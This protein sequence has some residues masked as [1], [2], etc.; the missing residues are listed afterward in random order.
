MKAVF[1]VTHLGL[2]LALLDAGEAST[3]DLDTAT[4]ALDRKRHRLWVR[5][6]V[7]R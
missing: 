6:R 1:P 3:S 4:L 5:T 2:L 7:R